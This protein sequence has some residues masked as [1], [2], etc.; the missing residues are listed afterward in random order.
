MPT[1]CPAPQQHR[2]REK[3]KIVQA[4]AWCVRPLAR[5]HGYREGCFEDAYMTYVRIANSAPLHRGQAGF[6]RAF[7]IYTGRAS[8]SIVYPA[9]TGH[10]ARREPG[11]LVVDKTVI[12][13][14]KSRDLAVAWHLS[15][16][17]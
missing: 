2:D 8:G 5:L 11:I 1:I 17:N 3:E 10:H 9:H 14:S 15:G 12:E 4:A 16:S 7:D 6:T 13:T